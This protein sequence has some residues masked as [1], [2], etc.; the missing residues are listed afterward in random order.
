VRLGSLIILPT[1]F[2][3]DDDDDDDHNH[4]HH[5]H[6]TC[7]V[8]FKCV[9]FSDDLEVGHDSEFYLPTVVYLQEFSIS[10]MWHEFR[11]HMVRIQTL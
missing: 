10:G 2:G 9:M 4:N 1:N 3:V 7:N 6:S 11:R 8:L 5:H